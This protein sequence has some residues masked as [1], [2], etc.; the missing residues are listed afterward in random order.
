MWNAVGISSDM[1][2]NNTIRSQLFEYYSN[3]ELFAQIC[4][5]HMFQAT[6]CGRLQESVHGADDDDVAYDDVEQLSGYNDALML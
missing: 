1:N 2:M 4:Y 3:T 6:G 5:E